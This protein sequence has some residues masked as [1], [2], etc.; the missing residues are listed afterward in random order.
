MNIVR[1]TLQTR[2][3]LL[4]DVS[5]KT[6]GVKGRISYCRCTNHRKLFPDFLLNKSTMN[7]YQRVV[8]ICESIYIYIGTNQLPK[9]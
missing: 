7:N 2:D 6:V 3:V 9:Q 4:F 1:L 5:F 8:I